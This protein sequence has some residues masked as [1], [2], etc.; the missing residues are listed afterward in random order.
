MARISSATIEEVNARTDLVALVGEYTRLEKRGTDY[1][2]CCPFHSEKTPSFHVVPD[3]KMCHCFGCGQ[4]GGVIKFYQEME[5]LSFFDATI[6]LAKKIGVEVIYDG[7]NDYVPPPQDN[8]KEEYTKLYTKVAGTYHYFLTKTDMGKPV[9]DY[10]QKR[11]LNLEIIERF[12]LGYSPKDRYWLKKFLLSKNYSEEFLSESG[13]FSKNYKDISFF[14][15]R[16]MF[17]ICNRNGDV[18][19]F[20]G[21]I[22]EGDG[23]KYINSKDLLQYKKGETLYGFHLAKDS[24]RQKKAVVFCEGNMDVIAYHQGGITNAVAPLGTALTPEQVKLISGFADTV[25]LSF[26]SD[27]AGQNATMKAILLCRKM[28]LSVRVIEL[29]NGKDPSEILLKFGSENLTSAVECA[30]LDSDYLLCKLAKDYPV[31]TPEGKMKAAMA[32]FPYI[33]SL[34]S[35]IQKEFCFEQ[36]ALTLSLRLEAVKSDY[37]NR[38]QAQK[39]YQNSNDSVTQNLRARLTVKPNAELRAVLAVIANM[40]YFEEMRKQLTV[41]DFEDEA[42]KNLFIILEECYREGSTSSDNILAKC[43]NEELQKLI[44]EVVM[45]GEFNGDANLV[46]LTIQESIKTVWKNSLERKRNRL[47]NRIRQFSAT[48]FEEQKILS[49]M[50]NEKM[51]LDRQLKQLKG[52]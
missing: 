49:E 27:S 15:H 50:L 28:D 10:L 47:M 8:K 9:M 38:E 39:K 43:G 41:D 19:A 22:L 21:R 33:D 23:P 40:D 7:N 24:I 48:N 12:Q 2:G 11:G 16:L 31:D 14:N 25:Y 3:K 20:G 36:L 1:W 17:P 6:A 34:K 32:F 26:D 45:S 37:Y 18:V 5:K 44:A 30:K 46:N 13:L 42:A 4:G 51:T 29:K 35:D 52:C